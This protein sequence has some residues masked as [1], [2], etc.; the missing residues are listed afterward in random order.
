MYTHPAQNVLNSTSKLANT[1][2]KFNNVC[3][4]PQV[5]TLWI[6][7]FS[8]FGLDSSQEGTSKDRSTFFLKSAWKQYWYALKDILACLISQTSFGPAQVYPHCMSLQIFRL[9]RRLYFCSLWQKHRK[10]DRCE[11]NYIRSI[12][13]KIWLSQY[14]ALEKFTKCARGNACTKKTNWRKT[15]KKY[16]NADHLILYQDNYSNLIVEWYYYIFQ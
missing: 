16:T 1:K 7:V 15:L 6:F 9:E 2:C 8:C 14:A 3:G 13:W 11:I 5:Y 4:H 12:A 10:L